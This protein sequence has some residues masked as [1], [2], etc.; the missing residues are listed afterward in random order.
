MYRRALWVCPPIT[1]PGRGLEPKSCPGDSR[2]PAI[3]CVDPL[4]QSFDVLSKSCSSTIMAF[5]TGW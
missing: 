4:E 1:T 2:C 3:L 5:T